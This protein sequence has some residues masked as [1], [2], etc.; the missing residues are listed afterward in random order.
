MTQGWS[1]FDYEGPARD[2]YAVD[3][4]IRYPD[5]A[6]WYSHVEKFAG[7]SG[8]KDGLP[9]LPD[10]EFL[11]PLDL[12]CVEKHLKTVVAREYKAQDRH[13]IYGRCAHLPLRPFS[14]V[15]SIL[16]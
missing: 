7:I 12:T 13:V 15:H 6:P 3:W 11:P 9:Q 14:V 5:L 10:G 1:D 8:N 2:G 16:Y 4:P